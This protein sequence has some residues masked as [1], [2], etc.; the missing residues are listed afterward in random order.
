MFASFKWH[1]IEGNGYTSSLGHY[2]IQKLS[3][4]ALGY[5]AT[6]PRSRCPSHIRP[7][8]SIMFLIN[9]SPPKCILTPMGNVIFPISWN[10]RMHNDNV[11]FLTIYYYITRLVRSGLIV[12]EFA[13]ANPIGQPLLGHEDP[14]SYYCMAMQH[15]I[16]LFQVEHFSHVF[17][18]NQ[19][20]TMFDLQK[21]NNNVSIL[22][23][24]WNLMFE[25]YN[26]QAL[27]AF[28][29]GTMPFL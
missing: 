25:P 7:F 4:K 2:R 16:N 13:M 18:W 22:P 10:P 27:K 12:P 6:W 23:T 17:F 3:S 26:E 29:N 19:S 5:V 28:T 14:S 21:E 8:P 15:S 9:D 24:P 11:L 1:K 20:F